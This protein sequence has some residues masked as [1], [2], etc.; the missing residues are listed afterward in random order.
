MPYKDTEKRKEYN[1]EY[2]QRP[3]VKEKRIENKKLYKQRPEVKEKTSRIYQKLY[4][5][6]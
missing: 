2:N 5:K 1:R 6:T 3:E 4:T